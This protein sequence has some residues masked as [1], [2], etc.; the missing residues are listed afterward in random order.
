MASDPA[1][2]WYNPAMIEV[3]DSSHSVHASLRLENI[4]L[5]DSGKTAGV[6]Y[7]QATTDGKGGNDDTVQDGIIATYDGVADITL[8]Q[9]TTIDGYGG[10]SAVRLS[11]G[12]LVMESGRRS[13][14]S[15]RLARYGGRL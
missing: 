4:T 14:D 3:C 1:R 8:G 5:A 6:R 13:M 15:G 2:S 12:R 11:G 10:M 9:G 7:S